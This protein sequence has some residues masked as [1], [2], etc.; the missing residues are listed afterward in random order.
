[1]DANG[2][3]HAVMDGALDP[4][5]TI[6]IGIRGRAWHFWDFS[7]QTG[8]RVVSP[9]EFYEN[10]VA[11]IIEEARKIVGNGPCY[12]TLDNDALDPSCMPGT[13]L[14]EPFG[15]MA[16][17]VM[18]LIRGLRGLNLVGADIAEICPPADPTEVSANLGAGLCFEMLCIL[19]EAHVTR[20]GRTQQTHWI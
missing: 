16:R 6:Q 14:P 13:G 8:M 10:G 12:L 18:S 17:D 3:R 2:L 4:E 11:S 1:M 20:T 9:E 15:L 7:H 19:A 5:R